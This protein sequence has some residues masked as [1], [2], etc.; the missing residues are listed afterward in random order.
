MP[1]GIVGLISFGLVW[2]FLCCYFPLARCHPSLSH[3][4]CTVHCAHRVRAHIENPKS[5][6]TRNSTENKLL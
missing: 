2:L 4:H 3:R 5:H 1:N 6:S